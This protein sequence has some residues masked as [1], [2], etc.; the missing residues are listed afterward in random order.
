MTNV[1]KSNGIACMM[2]CYGR[3]RITP[4][5]IVIFSH[6]YEKYSR[7]MFQYLH[8]VPISIWNKLLDDFSMTFLSY[9]YITP[10]LKAKVKSLKEAKKKT[11]RKER[12]SLLA[13]EINLYCL[14]L[15]KERKNDILEGTC[16]VFLNV[17]SELILNMYFFFNG[18]EYI[19]A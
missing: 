11:E 19:H 1:E 6:K 2:R 5:F 18:L 12:C 16:L 8:Q 7:I 9:L 13:L 17:A 14:Y 3:N 4:F 10:I 15:Y